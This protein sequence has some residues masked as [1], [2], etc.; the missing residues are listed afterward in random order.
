MRK[1]RR[2]KMH[3]TVHSFIPAELLRSHKAGS[4]NA[5][6]YISVLVET[7]LVDW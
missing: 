5:A 6:K 1:R 3:D 7:V 4:G 2:G